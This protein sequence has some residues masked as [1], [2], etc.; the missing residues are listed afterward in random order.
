MVANISFFPSALLLLLE[1]SRLWLFALGTNPQREGPLPPLR[2]KA[3]RS[4][5][6]EELWVGGVASWRGDRGKEESVS[7]WP[8]P[9]D[10]SALYWRQQFPT[11]VRYSR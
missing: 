9:L 7:S 4:L 11:M 6:L 5:S 2:A 1:I 3:R 8:P 10:P